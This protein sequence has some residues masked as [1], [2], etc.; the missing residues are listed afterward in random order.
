MV[1]DLK[2]AIVIGIVVLFNAF[3]AFVQEFRAEAAVAA[4][5][6]MLSSTA[7]VRRAGR[8]QVAGPMYL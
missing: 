4:L 6:K 5:R 1:G 2:D 8:E 3:L 7:R